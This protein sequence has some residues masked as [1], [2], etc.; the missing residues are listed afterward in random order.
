VINKLVNIS[1]LILSSFIIFFLVVVSGCSVQQVEYNVKAEETVI[2][3]LK[4]YKRELLLVPG[5]QI[6]VAVYR[7]ADVSRTVVVRPDGYISIP[8]LDEIKVAGMTLR[9]LD[10]LIT[11]RLSNRLKNP[12]VTVILIN[13]LEPMV[14]VFGDVGVSKPVPLRQARTLAQALAHAGGTTRDSAIREIA[15]V[16]LGDDG[17]IRMHKIKDRVEAPVGQFMAYQNIALKAE[18]LI[19]VPENSRSLAGRFL[20]DFIVEPLQAFNLVLNPYFQFRILEDRL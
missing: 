8:L 19:V 7:N 13:P 16:R 11:S 2:K 3:S 15:L 17:Y 18:D 20:Q 6:E 14:Y 10:D 12:E 4:R 9:E 1:T 5:D